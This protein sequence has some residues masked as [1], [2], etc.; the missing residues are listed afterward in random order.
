MRRE[1][2][3]PV[4]GRKTHHSAVEFEGR[5]C[6]FYHGCEL[7]KGVGHVRFAKVKEIFYD[8]NGRIS[9]TAH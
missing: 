6:L 4:L 8:D 3:E 9:T 7:S 2:L 5:T 1:I